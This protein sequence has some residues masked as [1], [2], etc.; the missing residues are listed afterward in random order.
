MINRPQPAAGVRAWTAVAPFAPRPDDDALLRSRE[1]LMFLPGQENGVAG[2]RL[3]AAFRSP[4]AG[5]GDA[6]AATF[7]VA[8]VDGAAHW[9]LSRNRFGEY[10]FVSSLLWSTAFAELLPM[11]AP[12]VA[13]GRPHRFDPDDSIIETSPLALISGV[14]WRLGFSPSRPGAP[15]LS[16]EAPER[17]AGDFVREVVGGRFADIRVDRCAIGWSSWF[18]HAG[19]DDSW[20]IT[21]KRHHRVTVLCTTDR[22]P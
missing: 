18:N 22:E 11:L 19:W 14:T 2:Q 10:G 1:Q 8:R 7:D 9:Y 17:L 12:D 3:L 5:Y 20:V 6:I 4:A 15:L 21:D 16:A 13:S